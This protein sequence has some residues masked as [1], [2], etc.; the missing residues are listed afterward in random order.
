MV[1]KQILD[2]RYYGSNAFSCLFEMILNKTSV[3]KCIGESQEGRMK[4]IK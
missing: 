2:Y 4:Q 1:K 3:L